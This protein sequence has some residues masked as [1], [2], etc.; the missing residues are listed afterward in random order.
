VQGAILWDLDGVL[1]D[2]GEAHYAA[3]RALFAERGE[4]ITRGQFAETFGMANLPILR[5]WLGDEPSDEELAALGLHKEELYRGFVED[6][7][8]PL[9]GVMEL[10]EAAKD[11]AYRQA[12][13]SSGEMANIV[14]VIRALGIA[15]YFDAL[16][17]GAFLP[18][19][20]PDPA[21]FLQSAGALGVPNSR[22]LVVEDGTV[23]VE[24]AR[25]AGM[26]CLAVTTTHPRERLQRADRVVDSLREI[27]PKELFELVERA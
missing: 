4:T 18:H 19:S 11:H 22:C 16:V 25:R 1:A 10:L 17:S 9:P 26:A 24:A 3:W 23:G 15:N 13:A 14:T 21:I 20:K 2:T 6:S 7:V 5:Q 8:T 12:V 27:S